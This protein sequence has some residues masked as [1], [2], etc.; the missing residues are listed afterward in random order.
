MILKFFVAGEAKPQGSTRAFMVGHGTR[1]RPIITSDN[2]GLK[3]WRHRIATEA[4]RAVD[5]GDQGLTA[6]A[7]EQIAVL[8][9]G[10]VRVTAVFVLP[11]P[12][13]LPKRVQ[14]HIKKPDLDKL[15][16]ALLDGITNIVIHD[17]SLVVRLELA[18]CYAADGRGP[19]VHVQVENAN[20]D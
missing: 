3:A 16:R 13:S 19:G 5:S 2:T 12:K 7:I 8:Y 20:A 1:R 6:R 11:R 10:P 9:S 14:H 17:D 18:K 15:G 4:Q